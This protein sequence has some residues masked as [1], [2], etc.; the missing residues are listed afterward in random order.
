M[1]VLVDRVRSHRC[2]HP[3]HS[4]NYIYSDTIATIRWHIRILHLHRTLCR[5][6]M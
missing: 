2:H 5:H 6:R 3:L 1:L 4:M